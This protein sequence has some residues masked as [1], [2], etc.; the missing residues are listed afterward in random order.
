M[1]APWQV[2]TAQPTKAHCEVSQCILCGS[3]LVPTHREK[4]GEPGIQNHVGPYT[5]VRRVAGGEICT[6]RFSKR[7]RSMWV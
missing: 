6:G 4:K 7:S 5:R 2:V 3:S 1:V